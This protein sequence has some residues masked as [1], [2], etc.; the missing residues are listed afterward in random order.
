MN[1]KRCRK[2]QRGI[3][4]DKVWEAEGVLRYSDMV[5][6]I[7]LITQAVV[8]QYA[9]PHSTKGVVRFYFPLCWY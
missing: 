4:G 8:E 2:A 5:A 3:N 6:L 7:C 9:P 1:V